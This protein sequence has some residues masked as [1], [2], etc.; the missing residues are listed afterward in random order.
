MTIV[1]EN[2][3]WLLQ[4]CKGQPWLEE[5]GKDKYGCYVVY[6]KYMDKTVVTPDRTPDGQQV[7][8]H[9]ATSLLTNQNKYL[10]IPES[11]TALKLHVPKDP[12]MTFKGDV[13]RADA[14]AT[15]APTVDEVVGT[16]EEEKSILYLQKELDRLEKQ[17]GSYTL[18]DIFYEVHDQKNAVTNASERY[19][20]VRKSL[21]KLYKLYGFD[22]IYEELD[23]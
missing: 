4:Q 12:M 18:Q 11:P 20:E 6:V 10:N 8:C 22:T 21:E 1:D 16:E 7:K 17:C 2:E 5:I 14:D 3:D 9:F 23:G 19:L 13:R 15:T